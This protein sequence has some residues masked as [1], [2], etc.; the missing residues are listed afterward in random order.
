MLTTEDFFA[1]AQWT[2]IATLV[3]A[4]FTILSFLF[5]WGFRFALLASQASAPC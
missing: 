5:K 3:F 1:Y 4:A 2:G